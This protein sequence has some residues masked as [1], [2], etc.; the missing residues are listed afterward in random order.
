[1]GNADKEFAA[2]DCLLNPADFS[3]IWPGDLRPLNHAKRGPVERLASLI[4]MV[5]GGSCT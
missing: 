4:I 2:I 5:F 3:A 1:M